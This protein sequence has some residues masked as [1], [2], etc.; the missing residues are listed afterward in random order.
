MSIIRRISVWSVISLFAVWPVFFA[1]AGVTSGIDATFQHAWGENVGWL[2]WGTTQGNVLV[3]D[4]A[5]TGYVWGE[6]VGWISLNCSNTGSCATVDY[7]VSN[8]VAG[9]L[10]GFAWGENV[11]WISFS[12]ENT[13]SCGTGQY[14]VTIGGTGEFA[15]H[16]W[17]ENIGW[18]VFNC[19]TTTSCGSVNYKVKTAGWLPAGGGGG[20]G[21][22][23]PAPPPP[24]VPAPTPTSTVTPTPSP[25]PSPSVTPSLTPTPTILPTPVPAATPILPTPVGPVPPPPP[26]VGP[27]AGPP[28][29]P[30]PGPPAGPPPP[31]GTLPPL[32][33]A[34]PTGPPGVVSPTPPA[35]LPSQV[36]ETISE[37]FENIAKIIEQ[38]PAKEEA[39]QVL[40]VAGTLVTVT[41]TGSSLLSVLGTVSDVRA[42]GQHLIITLFEL[43]G[44]KRRRQEW[45]TVY[46][47]A[48]KEPVPLVKVSLFLSNGR[49]VE[50]R[51]TDQQGRYGFLI[52]E[53]LRGSDFIIKVEKPGYTFPSQQVTTPTDTILYQHVYRGE[54][55][56]VQSGSVANFDVPVDP[57]T[58]EA[59]GLKKRFTL[60]FSNTFIRVL[61][62]GFWIATFMLPISVYLN[63]T[64]F[65]IAV[66]VVYAVFTVMRLAGFK[67]RPYGLVT[68]AQGTPV[69]YSLIVLNDIFGRRKSF[70]VSDQNGRYFI[71]TEK[72][73]Y[74]MVKS[75]PAQVI[76]G[77]VSEE[78]LSTQSGWIKKKVV[79]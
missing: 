12:C 79:I 34:T 1:Y 54:L 33:T 64:P 7:K 42:I 58:P 74:V 53:E 77:R 3:S 51:V 57:L 19:S 72:G 31:T 21:G 36:V 24:P 9:V 48:T 8:T 55:I 67:Q 60:K 37:V 66:L 43:L 18:I 15:G 23:P 62:I 22:P 11:G 65:N 20:G 44:L 27:P 30:P 61:D 17:G 25:T 68:D 69:P 14:G 70:S 38:I 71:L 63:P 59:L 56:N 76:P 6:N 46:N 52:A 40:S 4:T 5:L 41:S 35:S 75:T 32:P 47:A 49:L 29:G 28:P 73:D 10:S 13:G 26:P 16:A 39:S 78:Q 2:V 45:G 50:T